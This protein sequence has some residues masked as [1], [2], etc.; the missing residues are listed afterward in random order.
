MLYI[1][2]ALV[3]LRRKYFKEKDLFIKYNFPVLMS[4]RLVVNYLTY[5]DSLRP[6][7]IYRLI[8]RRLICRYKIVICSIVY[9]RR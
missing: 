8:R 1:L 2:Q 3:A 6:A 7:Y 9:D 4:R 5:C